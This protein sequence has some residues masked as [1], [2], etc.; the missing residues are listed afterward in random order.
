MTLPDYSSWLTKQQAAEAIGV[1][2]KT[3]EQLAK[4]R[5]IEQGRWRRDGRGNEFAVYNPDDVAR[6]AATRHQAPAPF[7]LPAVS[8][9]NGNGHGGIARP[10]PDLEA[11]TSGL[12]A[13]A[14]AL[15]RL[16][17]TPQNPENPQKHPQN[18]ENPQKLFLTVEEAAGVSG[19][20]QADLRRAI[21]AGE[22]TAR[23][24]GRGGWRIR[25]KDLEAL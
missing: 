21:A 17:P 19:L 22:L 4:D 16:A 7:V 25:R 5:R 9:S 10:G 14:A 11:L 18:P 3:V 24:T 6:I 23:K 12:T 2:T 13:L 8:P 1:S 20:P 15:H